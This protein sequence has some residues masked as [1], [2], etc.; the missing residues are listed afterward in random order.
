MT[1]TNTATRLS[2]IALLALSA[3]T[4]ASAARAQ[5]PEPG[6][7]SASPVFSSAVGGAVATMHGSGDDMQILYGIGTGKGGGA[8]AAKDDPWVILLSGDA[9]G[10]VFGQTQPGRSA[11]LTGGTG[12][13]PEVVY[14]EAAR[15]GLGREAWLS[16]GGEDASV[17]YRNGR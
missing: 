16:G 12:D 13:G 2:A 17:T 15:T 1:Q 9:D 7:T 14:L 8:F 5:A 11:R 4:L 3:S 10:S 6:F